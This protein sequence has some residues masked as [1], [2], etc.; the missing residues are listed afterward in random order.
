MCFER[1]E[2]SPESRQA[3]FAST[4]CDSKCTVGYDDFKD[5]L[6]SIRPRTN[7]SSRQLVREQRERAGNS[8]KCMWQHWGHR[9][10][11]TYFGSKRESRWA[12]EMPLRRGRRGRG[13]CVRTGRSK[14]QTLTE[15]LASERHRTTHYTTTAT[16]IGFDALCACVFGKSQ[17]RF[18]PGAPISS[19][20]HAPLPHRRSSSALTRSSTLLWPPWPCS[21]TPIPKG[22]GSVP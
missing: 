10:K 12:G 19:P 4:V 11:S 22:S 9:R 18:S 21:R 17:V 20:V 5:P 1:I 3:L 2:G 16:N 14:K 13:C 15:T 6:P 8:S 7:S